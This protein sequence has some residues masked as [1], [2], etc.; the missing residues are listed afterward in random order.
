MIIVCEWQKYTKFLFK[1]SLKHIVLL[2]I[3]TNHII[4]EKKKWLYI[5][6]IV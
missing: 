4:R 5:F 3:Y 1:L 2:Y 6:F